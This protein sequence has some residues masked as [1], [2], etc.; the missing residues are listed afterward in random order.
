MLLNATRHVRIPTIVYIYTSDE[1]AYVFSMYVARICTVIHVK[2]YVH[3]HIPETNS[4]TGS[5]IL[6]SSVVKRYE[7]FP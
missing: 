7:R 1:C 4:T 6:L 2:Y 5:I 3:V